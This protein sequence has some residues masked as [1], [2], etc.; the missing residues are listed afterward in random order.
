[1]VPTVGVDH[2]PIAAFGTEAYTLSPGPSVTVPVP[3]QFGS[4]SG[5]GLE[6]QP[7]VSDYNVLMIVVANY[8]SISICPPPMVH[9]RPCCLMP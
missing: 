7:T 4:A 8:W 1:M 2:A 5:P 6:T 9:Y 3:E